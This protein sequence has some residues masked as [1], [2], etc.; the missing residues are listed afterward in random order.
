L[1]AKPLR[2]FEIH[3]PNPDNP[4]QDC[5]EVLDE[6]DIH[7][8]YWDYWYRAMCLKL[9]SDIVDKHYSWADCLDD[10]IVINWAKEL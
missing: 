9:G 7:K 2:R 4:N 10:W 1:N 5:C 6:L 3:Y 8:Q